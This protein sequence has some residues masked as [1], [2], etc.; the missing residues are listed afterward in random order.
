M[1]VARHLSPVTRW[2]GHSLFRVGLTKMT[3]FPLILCVKNP[4]YHLPWFFV[5]KSILLSSLVTMQDHFLIPDTRYRP[6]EW[7]RLMLLLVTQRCSSDLFG[8]KVGHMWCTLTSADNKSMPWVDFTQILWVS[9]FLL[10]R[11]KNIEWWWN[12]FNYK[13]SVRLAYP[14][15]T[16]LWWANFYLRGEICSDKKY[17]HHPIL[18]WG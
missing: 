10:A 7:Y 15:N 11:R 14:D 4:F 2:G 12:W 1:L 8:K 16:W 9:R 3:N 6:P 5:L 17:I 13:K 18:I